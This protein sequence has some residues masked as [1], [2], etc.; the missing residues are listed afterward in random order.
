MHSSSSA[1][2]KSRLHGLLWE[3]ATKLPTVVIVALVVLGLEHSGAL[4]GLQT[5][6]LDTW[7]LASSGGTDTDVVIVGIDDDDYE[8]FF[9]GKSPLAPEMLRSILDDIAAAQPKAIG[10]DIDT[11]NRAFKDLAANS[12]TLAKAVWARDCRSVV[13]ADGKRELLREE[14]LGG[15]F[16]ELRSEKEI[17]STDP[18]SGVTL[19]PQDSDGLVRR[20]YQMVETHASEHGGEAGYCL[21]LPTAIAEITIDGKSNTAPAA[22]KRTEE[23]LLLNVAT[24]KTARMYVHHLRQ[25]AKSEAW[26]KNSPL[27]GKIVLLGGMYHA[28]R[29]SY[30]TPIGPRYGVELIAQAIATE[31]R[32][33]GIP[34][35]SPLYQFFL[36]IVLGSVLVTLSHLFT[37]RVA[38]FLNLFGIVVLAML[39]SWIAF[40]SLAYWFNY[41]AVLAGVAIHIQYDHIVEKRHLEQEV[42]ELREQLAAKEK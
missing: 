1:R 22:G 33:G 4:N 14:I 23:P 41:G 20:Y 24:A 21:S 19:F 42:K 36:D 5:V 35:L 34:E 30:S 10:I 11:S 40:H 31:L 28:A 16:K 12:E 13:S 27:K 18:P 29:D 39:G 7:L 2:P 3:L 38:F 17:I 9:E 25:A 8:Q 32:G 6:A 37:G 15:N 26:A